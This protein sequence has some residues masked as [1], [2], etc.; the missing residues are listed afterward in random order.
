MPDYLSLAAN[1]SSTGRPCDEAIKDV[2]LELRPH[3]RFNLPVM[4]Q[5][6]NNDVN[7]C[8]RKHMFVFI[9]PD[10]P[11]INVIDIGDGTVPI[12]MVMG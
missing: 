3:S 4:D 9:S 10:R 2:A 1:W 11:L 8:T 12:L 6:G 5:E 7:V